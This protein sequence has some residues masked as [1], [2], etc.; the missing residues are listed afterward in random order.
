MKAALVL[1]LAFVA[2]QAPN[3]AQE[4]TRKRAPTVPTTPFVQVSMV[5]L[6]PKEIRLGQGSDRAMVTVQVWH[7]VIP[8][9]RTETV[10]LEV[11]TF[12][13]TPPKKGTDATYTPSVQRVTLTGAGGVV[14]KTVEVSKPLC[15]TDV[16]TCTLVIGASLANPSAG[17][18]ILQPDPATNAQATLTIRNQ[19]P[20]QAH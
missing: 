18:T 4:Q 20:G 15:P 2:G 3:S 6:A 11:C 14:D 13:T 17:V 7:Q 19:Q 9:G 8:E 16:P 10:D 1:T 5:T 12:S